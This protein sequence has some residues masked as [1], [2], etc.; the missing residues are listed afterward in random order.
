[1]ADA[2]A[3]GKRTVAAARATPRA[4]LKEV[5]LVNMSMDR[6]QNWRQ[7]KEWWMVDS[8]FA[9]LLDGGLRAKDEGL[10][11]T[12]GLTV[13]ERT[14]PD[15]PVLRIL[16]HHWVERGLRFSKSTHPFLSSHIR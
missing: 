10:L 5:I 12:R 11:Y 3:Q 15:C 8:E 9:K 16:C 7:A 13:Y 6:G 4:N 2:D 14:G 1:M